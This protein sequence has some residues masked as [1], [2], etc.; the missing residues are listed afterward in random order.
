V[1]AD[2]VLLKIAYKCRKGPT[3]QNS[4]TYIYFSAFG[5]CKWHVYS[6]AESKVQLHWTDRSSGVKRNLWPLRD[7]WPIV[8]CQ[9]FCFL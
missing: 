2:K 3:Q 8:V 7:F 1:Q 6:L 5:T 9:L 4:S